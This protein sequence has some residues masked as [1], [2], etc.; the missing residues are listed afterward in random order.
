MSSNDRN[1]LSPPQAPGTSWL[2]LSECC[3]ATGQI[4]ERHSRVARAFL[5]LSEAAEEFCRV[6]EREDMLPA[7]DFE[8]VAIEHAKNFLTQKCR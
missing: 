3:L 5:A 8:R 6:L 4:C 7:S 1:T 2:D